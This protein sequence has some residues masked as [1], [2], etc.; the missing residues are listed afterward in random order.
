MR[1]ALYMATLSGIRYNSVLAGVLD[2]ACA[3]VANRAKWP[4][5]PACIRCSR[6]SMPC[7]KRKASLFATTERMVSE[8]SQERS[9][10]R[11]AHKSA[12]DSTNG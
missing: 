11:H 8:Q 4:W 3:N 9:H 10:L 1:T 12:L 5:W 7:F 2:P 6:F